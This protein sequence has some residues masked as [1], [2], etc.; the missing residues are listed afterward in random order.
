MKTTVAHFGWK[1]T[2]LHG[3]VAL[4]ALAMAW[5]FLTAG[6]AAQPPVTVRVL[7]PAAPVAVG[8]T[9]AVT[10][11]LEN[12]ENLGAFEFEYNFNPAI[13]SSTVNNIAL[14]P[15]L[16]AT[17]RTTG[18]LR[19]ASS[20]NRPGAP[21][22]GAYSYGNLNGPNGNGVL[23]TIAMT[24]VAPGITQLNLTGLKVTDAAGEELQSTAIA[25][26]V[27]IAGATQR[28]LYLPLLR[29]NSAS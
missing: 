19:L 12:V 8:Q 29:R 17:G 3:G 24:A 22:F 6:S 2:I 4:L 20:P 23:A 25:G 26:S 10:V 13:A 1:R 15:M 18:V 21:L 14:G 28:P 7:G 11:A 27:T 9:F 16:G 5:A